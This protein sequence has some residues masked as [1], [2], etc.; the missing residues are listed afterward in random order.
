MFGKKRENECLLKPYILYRTGISMS[1]A[2]QIIKKNI[3]TDDQRRTVEEIVRCGE[4]FVECY[5]KWLSFRNFEDCLNELAI[6]ESRKNWN[7]RGFCEVCE[8]ESQFLVDYEYA[9]YRDGIGTVPNWRERLVCPS[10]WCN[11]RMR[12]LIGKV[13]REFRTGMKVCLYESDT[14]V[15]VRLKEWLPDIRVIGNSEANDENVDL[16]I[17]NDL[18]GK[19]IDYRGAFKDANRRLN[20]S[21]KL[22]FYVPFNAN[23]QKTIEGENCVYGWD[24]LQTLK[25]CGFSDAYGVA[26]FGI[27]EGYLGYLQLYFEAIK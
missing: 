6:K 11:N 15:Y 3:F 27:N 10:C 18:L 2:A 13:K 21:G 1:D 19:S 7:Y 26:Y 24:L 12:F 25:E 22:I 14:P 17:S 20:K 23:S 5:R 16:L 4:D 9:D 8:T